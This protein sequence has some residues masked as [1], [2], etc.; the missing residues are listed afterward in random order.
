[1]RRASAFGLL[2]WAV[3]G[4]MPAKPTS[5]VLPQPTRQDVV[6]GFN[7]LLVAGFVAARVGRVDPNLETARFLRTQLRLK[8]LTVIETEPLRFHSIS[9]ATRDSRPDAVGDEIF[10]DAPF[11]RRLGEEYAGPLIVTG[12]VELTQLPPRIEERMVGPRTVR[13]WR[14]G[15]TLRLRVVLIDGQTGAIVDAASLRQRSAYAATGRESGL[16]IYF[17]LM[18]ATMPSVMELFGRRNAATRVLLW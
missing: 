12:V 7:R 16:S 10:G 11:W 8:G 13:V 5:V 14:P 2:L 17:K 1:M 9:A 18:E 3:I 15:F 6:I 4:C